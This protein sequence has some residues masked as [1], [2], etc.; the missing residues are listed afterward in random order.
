MRCELAFSCYG[1]QILIVDTAG[2]GVCARLEQ[3]LPPSIVTG[4]GATPDASFVV[5]RAEPRREGGRAGFR[6]VRRGEVLMRARSAERVADWLR[7][8]VDEAVALFSRRG[9]FV[10]AGVVGWR[11]R[12]IL[13][14][15]RSMSG[16]SHLVAELVR[17]GATYYS[18]EFAVLDD[19][20]LVHPYARAPVM[21]TGEDA[22]RP[23]NA[24]PCA[25]R[26]AETPLPVALVVST[27]YRPNATWL[28]EEVRGARAVL[29]IIDNTV[30]A[31]RETGHLLQLCTGIAPAL[32]TLQGV[33]PDATIV[34]PRLLAYLDAMLDGGSAASRTPSKAAVVVARA[35][36]AREAADRAPPGDWMA[37][38]AAPALAALRGRIDAGPVVAVRAADSQRPAPADDAALSVERF[39]LLLHWNGRFGNRMH[40]YAYGV[41]YARLHSCPFWLPS[42]WEGTELFATQH[43]TVAPDGLRRRLNAMGAAE[44]GIEPRLASAREVAPRLTRIKAENPR[45]NYRRHSGPVCFDSVCAFH[46]SIFPSMSR[47]HL[48]SVFEFSEAVKQLDSYKR[49]EDRQ[50]S[51]DVAHLRRDD[52][53]NPTYNQIHSQGYSVI[54]RASYLRAFEQ[55]GFDPER[56]EWV[57][58]D[59]RRQWHTDRP[60][61]RRGKWCYPTG[62]EVLPGIIFDWLEDF[63]RLY[64]A[65]TIFRANSS[66]SWWAAFLAP[67]ARVFSPIVDQQ[68][69]YGVDGMEEISVEFVEGNHPHWLYDNEDIVIG[70]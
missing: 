4:A 27:L 35:R 18:D 22:P 29:P 33:R 40:Q 9:L 15:G 23:G 1:A 50:G 69:I 3:T 46:P 6:I 47:R 48:L 19:D 5:D 66:F 31:R 54:S 24:E 59:Y 36:V 37:S 16:K 65:R 13:V 51:Y 10:H 70:A 21:R 25:Q 61:T 8:E 64:F 42:D 52:I 43:H 20:G 60:A 17:R 57:S 63:L 11:G 2:A 39:I 55:Y 45:Q 26:I 41:T 53:S 34:A 32:V 38:S 12:A 28:P 67:H 14:P 7:R 44:H 49:L 58:D 56:V 62:S 68:H 30:L